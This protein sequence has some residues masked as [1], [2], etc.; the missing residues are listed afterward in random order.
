MEELLRS[1]I[2]VWGYGLEGKSAV[3]FL[4]KNNVK[5]IVVATKDLI[6]ED[7]KNVKFIA[8]DDILKYNF[9]VVIKSSGVS[10]YKDICKSRIDRNV[11]ITSLLNILLCKIAEEKKKVK[12]IGITGTKG[13]STTVSMLHHILKNMGYRVAILGNIGVSFLDAIDELDNYDYLILE[14]SSCQI[15][16]MN[17]NI[18]YSI[19]LNL[20]REHIDWHITHEN[21][22]RDKINIINRSTKVAYNGDNE[23]VVKYINKY[24]TDNNANKFLSFGTKNGF[25]TED[26]FIMYGNKKIIDFNIFKNIRGEHIFRNICGVLTILQQ[27]NI[28][29]DL[30]LNTLQTFKTLQH[31]LYIF[32]NDEK[33]GTMFVN[34]SI[35]T[36]PEATIEAIKTFA[37]N[38]NSLFLILGGFDRQQDYSQLANVIF[39]HKDKIKKIF[40]VGQTAERLNA[41]LADKINC[42]K[43]SNYE[44]LVKAIKAND[45]TNTTVLLS[46]AAASY[47]MFKNFEE[48]GKTFEKLML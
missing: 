29:I 31:R 37:N 6:N 40:L 38:K 19:I 35:S 43:Y 39:Q 41:I 2:L 1:K 10:I 16:T 48:R 30:A 46:P 23:T 18:N 47:D 36:I 12:V 15:A 45:L 3:D 4:L 34:D 44:D 22:F 21:Y 26:N 9:D 42:T 11:K 17:C 7:V 33:K 5:N 27:E 13:K 8:E 14:L 20:F 24:S 25:H 28:N 32:Y